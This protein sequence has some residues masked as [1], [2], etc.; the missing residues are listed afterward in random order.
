[1]SRRRMMF[2][3]SELPDGYKRCEYLQGLGTEETYIMIPEIDITNRPVVKFE[4]MY[5]TY[6]KDTNAFG[7][8]LNDIRFEH[9]IGWNGYGFSYNFANG[10]GIINTNSNN[11]KV[12]VNGVLKTVSASSLSNVQ[13]IFE[14]KDDSFYMN[15]VE[16]TIAKDGIYVRG[17]FGIAK[18]VY[19]FGT[20][21]GETKRYFAGKI[22][23]FYVENNINLVPALDPSGRPCMYDTITKHPFYNAGTGE[24]L[25]ELSGGY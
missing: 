3:K 19:I 13:L 20:N 17:S 10:Y 18:D 25:Y 24:F 8:I 14:Y 6:N 4:V 7:S 15:G 16:Q 23:S 22:F 1:M 2:K 5:P 9:G 12:I 11:V 21:R